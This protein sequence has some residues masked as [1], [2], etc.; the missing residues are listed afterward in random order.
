MENAWSESTL[1]VKKH[2]P[3]VRECFL[4]LSISLALI[5]VLVTSV[6]GVVVVS[7][8]PSPRAGLS[9]A[10]AAVGSDVFA[11]QPGT[12]RHELEESDVVHPER[13]D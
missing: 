5:T 1:N 4:S 8:G 12:R 7:K 11:Q 9:R 6:C 10:T 13:G 3:R 2:A